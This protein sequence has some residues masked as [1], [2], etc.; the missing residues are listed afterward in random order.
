MYRSL[1]IHP[2]TKRRLLA[3]SK[4]ND[5]A[6]SCYKHPCAGFS[7]D[8]RFL[9]MWVQ[10]MWFLDCMAKYGWF[11]NKLPSSSQES[12]PFWIL[13]RDVYKPHDPIFLPGYEWVLALDFGCSKRYLI[14]LHYYFRFL[15]WQ[16]IWGVSSYV[17]T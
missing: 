17:Y 11:C 6:W 5:Y 16:R 7:V 4:C 3:A 12:I 9:I 1:F 2:F 10:S 14:E 8:I 13:F 15:C